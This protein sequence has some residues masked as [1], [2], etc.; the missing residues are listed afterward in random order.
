MIAP[1]LSTPTAPGQL[2]ESSMLSNSSKLNPSVY[3]HPNF[4]GDPILGSKV[5]GGG[6]GGGTNLGAYPLT[7]LGGRKE[8]VDV[9]SSGAFFDPKAVNR[10]RGRHQ[11]GGGGG[12]PGGG[13]TG[14][15]GGSG[16]MISQ[17]TREMKL[18]QQLSSSSID[19]AGAPGGSSAELSS[20]SG[21]N[22]QLSG[23]N[24]GSNQ[25][26]VGS[27]GKLASGGAAAAVSSAAATSAAQSLAPSSTAAAAAVSGATGAKTTATP[28]GRTTSIS[29]SSGYRSDN[30]IGFDSKELSVL[31]SAAGIALGPG[32][33]IQHP[34][35]GSPALTAAAALTGSN[36]SIA[37][38]KQ[39][40]LQNRHR[41]SIPSVT[42]L[43]IPGVSDDKGFSGHAAKEFI[44]MI[45]PFLKRWA[46]FLGA[47]RMSRRLRASFHVRRPVSTRRASC[48]IAAQSVD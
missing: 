41:N 21:S 12:N 47:K 4:G 29:S 33:G 6:G 20:N 42:T 15:G 39:Q 35:V 44:L 32:G 13:L 14:A 8:N 19:A 10:P 23:S 25:Q 26:L 3:G 37:D 18:Q 48:P 2:L 38:L 31:P 27:S 40:Q 16:D 30:S 22:Q 46:P 17:L 24:S 36:P 1:R 28:A 9:T 11:Q 45:F 5:P 7:V 34:A 43:G